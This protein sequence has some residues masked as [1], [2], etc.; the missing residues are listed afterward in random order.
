M[1]KFLFLGVFFEFVVSFG[2]CAMGQVLDPV[3][4]GVLSG[5]ISCQNSTSEPDVPISCTS[6]GRCDNSDRCV[7]RGR[8]FVNPPGIWKVWTMTMWWEKVGNWSDEVESF[9]EGGAGEKKIKFTTV[10]CGRYHACL[11]DCARE[12]GSMRCQKGSDTTDKIT[13][14]GIQKAELDGDCPAAP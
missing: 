13:P 8:V 12:S 11:T 7:P 6:T 14:L 9:T 4:C 2:S 3:V 1:S 5:K 10:I